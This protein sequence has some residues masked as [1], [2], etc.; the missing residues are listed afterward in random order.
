MFDFLKYPKYKV[1]E[2]ANGKFIAYCRK[3]R[4]SSWQAI[5]KASPGHVYWNL[6]SCIQDYS[7]CDDEEEAVEL[8]SK[9]MKYV[10]TLTITQQIEKHLK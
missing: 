6:P 8:V 4:G 7:V 3:F 2:L 5:D 9:A 10:P 1:E